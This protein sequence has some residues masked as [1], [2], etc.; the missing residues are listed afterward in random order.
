MSLISG[1][2]IGK[3]TVQNR[4]NDKFYTIC[5]IDDDECIVQYLHPWIFTKKDILMEGGVAELYFCY[6]IEEEKV[7]R[8]DLECITKVIFNANDKKCAYIMGYIF[9]HNSLLRIILRCNINESEPV[10][11]ELSSNKTRM[12]EK[13]DKIIIEGKTTKT[14]NYVKLSNPLT[15]CYKT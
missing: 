6:C 5:E 1:V 3:N 13:D 9:D 15:S 4:N 12:Y 11:C 8:Y 14:I 7:Y 10:I 2:Y